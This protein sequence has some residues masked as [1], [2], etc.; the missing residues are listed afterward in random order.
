MSPLVC[1]I[2]V[3]LLNTALKNGSCCPMRGTGDC[4]SFRRCLGRQNCGNDAINDFHSK[5]FHERSS[6][7]L[8]GKYRART[9]FPSL[10]PEIHSAEAITRCQRAGTVSQAD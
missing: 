4:D 8:P 9:R 5:W 1:P 7:C 3:K 2:G 6:G 10:L